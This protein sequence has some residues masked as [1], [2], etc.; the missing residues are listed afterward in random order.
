MR[1]IRE[2]FY[3]VLCMNC[4]QIVC[5][6]YIISCIMM[7]NG[8]F[9]AICGWYT[10]CANKKNNSL[11][12]NVC[13]SNCTTNL[14]QTL[15]LYMWVFLQISV[16]HLICCKRYDSLSFK[17]QFFKRTCSCTL[18]IHVYRV[19][20]AQLF[21]YSS[22]NI[23]VMNVSCPVSILNRVFKM[24]ISCSNIPS[25][26]ALKWY[27]CCNHELWQQIRVVD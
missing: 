11:E 10:E 17:V 27:S 15:T 1:C 9:N 16:K 3:S 24:S 14:N 21:I 23:S 8:W 18:N 20:F 7:R 5:E 2:A 25:K 19:N 6:L 13:F 12:K 4:Y 22:L 26:S